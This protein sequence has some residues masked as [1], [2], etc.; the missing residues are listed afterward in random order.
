MVEVNGWTRANNGAGL[1]DISYSEDSYILPDLGTE[2]ERFDSD[3]TLWNEKVDGVDG[4]SSSA[5]GY[6]WGAMLTATPGLIG[7]LD[8]VAPH[9]SPLLQ[10]NPEAFIYLSDVSYIAAIAA[11]FLVS[12]ALMRKAN[13]LWDDTYQASRRAD[14]E[15]R[16][17]SLVSRKD[18]SDSN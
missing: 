9:G 17:W 12:A 13:R 6:A 3:G 10:S 16:I 2:N 8:Y 4:Y 18:E 15:D 14:E 7:L 11:S 1:D 5:F